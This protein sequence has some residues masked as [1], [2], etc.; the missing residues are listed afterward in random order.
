VPKVLII[1]LKSHVEGIKMLNIY[2]E[3]LILTF[4]KL[5]RVANFIVHM[6]VLL[7]SGNV[8]YYFI[9]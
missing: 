1:N 2:Y 9:Y 7:F 5:N 8:L 4:F 3:D 6:R